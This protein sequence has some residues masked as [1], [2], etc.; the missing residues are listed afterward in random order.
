MDP[1]G[2]RPRAEISTFSQEVVERYCNRSA[3]HVPPECPLRVKRSSTSFEVPR[4]AA[5]HDRVAGRPRIAAYLA[6]DRRI[7][8]NQ[9]G[10]F[11]HYPELDR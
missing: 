8:F 9:S 4:V 11:R 6:S 5:L 7:A 2:Q 3:A 10:I 1:P